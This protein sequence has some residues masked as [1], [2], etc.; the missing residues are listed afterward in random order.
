MEKIRFGTG[1]ER[2]ERNDAGNRLFDEHFIA[3]PI[4]A[5]SPAGLARADAL[6]SELES[7]SHGN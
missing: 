3:K 2:L 5:G 1:N 7:K 4:F 6:K